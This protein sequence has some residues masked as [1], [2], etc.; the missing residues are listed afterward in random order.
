[1]DA[2]DM[3]RM[4]IDQLGDAFRLSL[5]D[6]STLVWQTGMDGW[7]R[8]GSIADVE[9]DDQ[10]ETRALWAP[11]PPPPPAAPARRRAA[12]YRG[13]PSPFEQPQLVAPVYRAPEPVYAD[14]YRSTEP[15]YADVY[16]SA[17]PVYAEAY[18]PTQSAYAATYPSAEPAYGA[19]YPS[20]EPAYAPA[21]P[22]LD[23]YMLPKRSVSL[24][25][26][27]D[28]R[29][30]PGSTRWG[31]W[32]VGALVIT[33]GVLVAYRQNLLR[34][35]ARRIG[36]ESAYIAGEQRATAFVSAKAPASVKGVLTKLSL[37][38]GPNATAPAAFALSAP[39]ANATP[40]TLA[41]PPTAAAALP[42]CAAT[43]AVAAAPATAPATEMKNEPAVKTVSFDSLPLLGRGAPAAR[44]LA[45][46]EPALAPARTLSAKADGDSA[47]DVKRARKEAL[48]AKFK[49]ASRSSEKSEKRASRNDDADEAP[50]P[51]AKVA[52]KAK[53][54]EPKPEAAPAPPR[55]PENALQRAMR[56]TAESDSKKLA[57]RRKSGD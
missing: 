57:A 8:L 26:K 13:M 18:P 54:A 11:P 23:P 21:F 47:A 29:R 22:A 20:A 37:L 12:T 6:A 56:L 1:M 39:V 19:A 15:A 45:P 10:D 17:E 48:E 38:P 50:E 35:G 49:A 51:K 2:D 33:A 3:K 27:I 25:D 7:R 5:I 43:P 30:A 44:V 41:T 36:V 28:F 52:A 14:A 46:S 55:G 16:P 53:K 32:F 9:D 31:R 4:N 42:P 34:D 40:A 24:P